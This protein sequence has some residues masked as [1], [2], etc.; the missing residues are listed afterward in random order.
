MEDIQL[1]EKLCNC[2]GASGFEDEVLLIAR[3]YLKDIA[4]FEED[5]MRNLYIHP[6][7]NK[8]NRPVVLLDAHSDEVG[9]MVQAVKPDGTL[10]FI[11]KI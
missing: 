1:I 5:S 6:K 10:R 3:E 4:D 11:P 2:R 7:Y 8:G 9:F